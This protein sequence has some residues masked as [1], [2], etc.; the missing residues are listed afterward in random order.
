M[1]CHVSN[2]HAMSEFLLKTETGRALS[3]QRNIPVLLFGQII[4]DTSDLFSFW[5]SSERFF[6]GSNLALYESKEVD[7]LIEEIKT[8]NHLSKEQRE[9]EK[10]FWM[11]FLKIYGLTN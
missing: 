10:N 7:N 6:P 5:H 11:S 2:R 1:A 9:P 3:L 4:G 8:S